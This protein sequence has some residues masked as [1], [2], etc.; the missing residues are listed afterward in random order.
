LIGI[1]NPLIAYCTEVPAQDT[2]SPKSKTMTNDPTIQPYIGFTVQANLIQMLTEGY[3]LNAPAGIQLRWQPRV[4][5][6]QQQHLSREQLTAIVH[7]ALDVLDDDILDD[8]ASRSSSASR[9]SSS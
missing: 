7:D 6:Q 4:P 3:Q 5:Q 2:I 1:A 9:E 8:G